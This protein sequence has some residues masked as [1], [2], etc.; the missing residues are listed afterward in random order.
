MS[1]KVSQ[2]RIFAQFLFLFAVSCATFYALGPNDASRLATIQSLVDHHTFI[3]DQSMF[4]WTGD[5]YLYNQ[6]FY[7]DKPALLSLYGAGIYWIL[8]IIFN[9]SLEQRSSLAIYL[10][11][12]FTTVI[13]TAIGL[14]YFYKILTE[15]FNISQRWAEITTLLA[16][17]G[18]LVLPYSGALNNNL[19]SGVLLI[20]AFYYFLKTTSGK[21]HHLIIT[22]SLISLA[23]SI[24]LNSFL[25]LLFVAGWLILRSLK[26]AIVFSLACLPPIAIWLG[27]NIHT[28]G[29][30]IPPAMNAPLWDYPGSAFNSQLLSG[31]AGHQTVQGFL[32]Y[33]FHMILGN[34][35]LIS[36]TPLLILAIY[37]I[38]LLWQQ[39]DHPYRQEYLLFFTASICYFML[40]VSRTVNYSGFAFGVR[41]F[42]TPMLIL[43]LPIALLES[44]AKKS[45]RFRVFFVFIACLSIAFSFLGT[46]NPFMSDGM[47]DAE[48]YFDVP[49]TLLVGGSLLATSMG[50]DGRR[51]T[52]PLARFLVGLSL[53]YFFLYLQ[54]SRWWRQARLQ[55]EQHSRSLEITSR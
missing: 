39:K 47:E 49:N 13:P 11:V 12:I 33:T 10:I 34:R 43:C 17:T 31:L 21:I 38:H 42:V 52:L 40:F 55:P 3:I 4:I 5:K 48:R 23:G 20:I 16:G 54:L 9:I 30:P 37:G 6:H 51:Q 44:P 19:V 26:S 8:K 22:G 25:Y 14:V 50:F 41:W 28:S 24:D 45:A 2:L 53:T 18:T 32:F 29:S 36:H 7:S 1:A 15:Q 35:G 27:L 46:F